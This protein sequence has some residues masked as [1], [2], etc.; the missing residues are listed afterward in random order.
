MLPCICSLIHHKCLSLVT[1]SRTDGQREGGGE[2]KGGEGRGGGGRGEL[3]REVRE[4][5]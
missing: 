5:W 2:G 3:Q 1:Y 4:L